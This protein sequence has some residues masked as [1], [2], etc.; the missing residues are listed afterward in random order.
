MKL[1]NKIL[2]LQAYGTNG[3]H[4]PFLLHEIKQEVTQIL[5]ISWGVKIRKLCKKFVQ[6]KYLF[7]L[8]GRLHKNNIVKYI[9][10]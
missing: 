7:S 1:K 4:T 8:N 5:S 2:P 9:N 10:L 6:R 3:L